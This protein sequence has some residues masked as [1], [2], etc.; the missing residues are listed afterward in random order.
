MKVPADIKKGWKELKQQNDIKTIAETSGFH[1]NTISEAIN[2]GVCTMEVFAVI[3]SFYA[4][5]EKKIAK[6]LAA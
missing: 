1:R 4:K 2:N 3:Q 5:R 6:F